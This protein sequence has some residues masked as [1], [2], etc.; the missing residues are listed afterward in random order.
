VVIIRNG[1]V[2]LDTRFYPFSAEWRHDIAS[3]T[4]SFMSAL[5]GIAIDKGYISGV[6]VPML[7]FFTDY[8]V[9]NRD[10]RKERITLEHLLRMRSGFECDPSNSE[11]TLTEMTN[12]ADWIQF[13]LDL[14]MADEPGHRYVYCSPNIH[15]LSAIVERSTGM[16]TFEFARQNLFKPLGIFDVEWL[17]DPQDFYR[18]WGDL[19]L[20]PLDMTKLGQLFINGGRWRG[21][22]IVSSQWVEESTTGAGLQVPGWPPDAGYTYLWYYDSDYYNA[23]GR[24]G[25]R[26]E[27]HP[28]QD[29]VIGLNAGSG[30]GD[31][32]PLTLEF[33]ETWV[34]GAIESDDP[35]PPNPDGVATLASRVTEAEASNEVP[36]PVP[37]LPSTA[38]DISGQTWELSANIY[39]LSSM[40][41]TFPGGDVATLEVNL[42]EIA[43]GP[44]ITLEI[45]LDNVQRF[46]PGRFGVKTASKGGWVAENRFTATMDELGLI[47]LWE[48]DLVFEGD[49]V[50]LILENLAGGELPA[51]ATGTPAR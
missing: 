27:V 35:L 24:G 32:W 10:A 2:V 31:Y 21:R 43:G 3:V 14:P 33:L 45:G 4:K 8:T 1:R 50:E 49:T 18:G 41:L 23:S 5:V 6:D 39:G 15:L 19:H 37:P 29:L 46:S 42:P 13:A 7:D 40:R 34:L 20:R 51:T 36:E 25:Q 38:Q 28:D 16:S 17:I 9:A 12:S 26:I 44:M 47:N 48:W 22:Q 11:A 30:I